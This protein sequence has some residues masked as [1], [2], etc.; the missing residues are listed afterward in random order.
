MM[1]LDSNAAYDLTDF[2]PQYILLRNNP[3]LNIERLL[4]HY[5]PK[6]LIADGSN[7]P[8]NTKRWKMSCEKQGIVFYDTR[9]KGALKINL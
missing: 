9:I 5:R 8:W 7:A 2:N 4:T 1:I 6:I 3:K